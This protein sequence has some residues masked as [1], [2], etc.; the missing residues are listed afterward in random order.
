MK[1][2][3]LILS[4][5]VTLGSF[6]LAHGQ[7]QPAAKEYKVGHVFSITLP[8][9]ISK[10]V[11]LNDAASIQYKSE[12]KGLY[13]YVVTDT[14]EE[15]KL[16][17]IN[18]ISIQEFYYDFMPGFSKDDEKKTIGKPISTAKNGINF[19]EVDYTFYSK[20]AEMDIYYLVGIV[21]TKKAFY[22]VL[23]W[24]AA[25]DKARFK[26]EFQKIMYSVKD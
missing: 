23:T 4:T 21:E 10:T 17:E 24:C 5:L 8:G 14:K 9:Y 19:I 18:Y 3:I 12:V 1:K 26:A 7:Q 2:Y 20:E 11:G 15:L 25:A 22:K 16:A 6:N 13:G